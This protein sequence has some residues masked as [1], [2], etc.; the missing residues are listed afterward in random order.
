[1]CSL[2][3]LSQI[4]AEV[5]DGLQKILGQKLRK[6]ILY[7]SYARGDFD[8]ES[9]IDILVLADLSDEEISEYRSKVGEISSDASLKCGV[10]VSIS[11]N[12]NDMFSQYL[13]ILPF[14][15][16]VVKDGVDLYGAKIGTLELSDYKSRD[17]SQHR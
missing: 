14:Y 2:N 16:N 1:M 13:D 12:R 3:Q 7:G 4:T 6:V 17:L 9:D 10:L 5:T 8:D 15:Q 11:L